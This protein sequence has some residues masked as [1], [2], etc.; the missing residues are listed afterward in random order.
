MS[1]LP[2]RGERARWFKIRCECG[3]EVDTYDTVERQQK[4]LAYWRKLWHID[5][6]KGLQCVGR[7]ITLYRW[8]NPFTVTGEARLE[9]VAT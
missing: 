9:K 1:E 7:P 4:E 6:R 8:L 3:W 2:L 5:S